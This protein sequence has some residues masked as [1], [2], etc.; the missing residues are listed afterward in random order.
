MDRLRLAL[1]QT[2]WD[3]ERAPMLRRYEE[4]L[5][6]AADSGAGLVGLQEFS[7]SP[8]FASRIDQANQ[9]WAEPAHGGPTH[10]FLGKQAQRHKLHIIGSIFERDGSQYWDT[11]TLYAP[12]GSLAG[13]TRKNHIPAGEG[14][15]EDHY[16]GPADDYPLHEVLG[17]KL[18]LPTCYDQWF[19]ELSRI[20]ALKGAELI[21]YPTAIGH[22]P[23]NLRVDSRDAWQTVMR[24]QAVANTVYMAAANRVGVEDLRFYGSSFVC[25]PA[26]TV[27]AQ[28][29]RDREQ[30]IMAELDKAY[31][32][33]WRRL[34]PL[35]RQRRP[36]AYRDILEPAD[37]GGR[38]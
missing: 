3:G 20:Y 13:K 36:Q 16:Y 35:L 19:P 30:L 37:S 31:L 34:F 1:V 17:W 18:A 11:A 25:D 23:T 8:Y 38:A 14:Y 21:F 32:G 12:D 10:E 28:A 7:I 4:L 22:E 29:G 27:L 9:R 5:Q 15:H 24:G 26:G 33:E 2:S 6:R